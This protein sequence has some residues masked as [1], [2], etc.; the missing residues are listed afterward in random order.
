MKNELSE[1]GYYFFFFFFL[2]FYQNFKLFNILQEYG[3]EFRWIQSWKEWLTI[4]R[5]NSTEIVS[6]YSLFAFLA[7]AE[8]NVNGYITVWKLFFH[9]SNKFIF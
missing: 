6:L 8:E 5:N 9:F 7:A 3:K 1:K 4:S 2:F